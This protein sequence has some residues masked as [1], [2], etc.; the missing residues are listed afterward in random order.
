MT[1]SVPARD[2]SASDDDTRTRLL[3]AAI[4]IA[5]TQGLDKVTYR[6]VGAQA[7]LS[8]SL[9]R[10]YFGTGEAMLLQALERAAQLDVEQSRI[11]S[12]T[13]EEFGRDLLPVWS[14]ERTRGMLQYDYMSRALRGRLPMEGVASLYDF[15]IGQVAE[16]LRE[17]GID[18]RDGATADVILAALDGLIL[19]HA[20]Y[21]SEERAERAIDTIR[22][23]LRLLQADSER[24][25]LDG[26]VN[27]PA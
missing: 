15:Y 11:R 20:A 25:R 4:H 6:S 10:F 9:V 13:I 7:G 18:D 14:D 16:T 19:Q 8:H 2:D 3:D 5:A 22:H 1:L 23:I 17:C 24:T 21:D 26:S 27:G 12:A